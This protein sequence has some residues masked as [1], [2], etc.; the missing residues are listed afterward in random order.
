MS[1]TQIP[2]DV[3]EFW[4][5]LS[6]EQRIALAHSVLAEQQIAANNSATDNIMS[7]G[8]MSDDDEKMSHKKAK[9]FHSGSDEFT[10]EEQQS[11]VDS[12]S[13]DTFMRIRSFGVKATDMLNL[14]L[15]C[16]GFGVL[17]EEAAKY[18]LIEGFKEAE[19]H[20][21]LGA[22]RDVDYLKKRITLKSAQGKSNDEDEKEEETWIGLVHELDM[23][24]SCWPDKIVLG[25][26]VNGEDFREELTRIN[27]PRRSVTHI[28]ICGPEYNADIEL[29]SEDSEDDDEARCVPEYRTK[30]VLSSISKLPHL[31]EIIFSPSWYS[32]CGG[33]MEPSRLCWLLSPESKFRTLSLSNLAIGSDSDVAALAAAFASCTSIETLCIT[34]IY[35]GSP[36]Q[37]VRTI[38]IVPLM[39]AIGGLPKLKRLRLGFDPTRYNDDEFD[40]YITES[41]DCLQGIRGLEYVPNRKGF[42]HSCHELRNCS[43]ISPGM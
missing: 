20:T 25:D 29:D 4:E 10:L 37:R 21:I 24:F 33:D 27:D 2:A 43:D 8:G 15:T 12:F 16:K 22:C 19:K 7:R 11:L 18:I 17:M 36:I 35:I 14:A 28:H 39:K 13:G 42:I 23:C 34:P 30:H 9:F 41:R 32:E 6:P 1:S 40:C 31:R 5:S 3:R 26:L 38:D